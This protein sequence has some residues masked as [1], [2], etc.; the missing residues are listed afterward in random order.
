VR[1]TAASF[2]PAASCV[3]VS[4][5]FVTVTKEGVHF[6]LR[7]SPGAKR[8]SIESPYGESA[9]K[10]KVAAPPVGGKANVEVDRFLL[11]LLGVRRSAVAVVRGAASRFKTVLVRGVE[12]VATQKALAANLP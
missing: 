4:K 12:E 10:L 11:K 5:G 8:T 2:A 9:V 7:V 3:G 1:E 6:S